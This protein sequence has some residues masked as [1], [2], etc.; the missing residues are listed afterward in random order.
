MVTVELT[1]QEAELLLN[2]MDSIN[3]TGDI[4]S[5]NQVF[6]Y[7]QAIVNLQAKINNQLFPEATKVAEPQEE[8]AE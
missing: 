2:A 1:R 6:G 7:I 5:R 3:Y 8:V 4:K